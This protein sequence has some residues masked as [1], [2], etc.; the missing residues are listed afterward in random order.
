MGQQTAFF[1]SLPSA[2]GSATGNTIE[3]GPSNQF[4]VQGHNVQPMYSGIPTTTNEVALPFED[5]QMSHLGTGPSPFVLQNTDV[6]P[7][8]FTETMTPEGAQEQ[9]LTRPDD[10]PISDFSVGK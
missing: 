3:K 9:P 8:P 1:I 5:Y 7:V 6:N 4:V 10:G 2:A